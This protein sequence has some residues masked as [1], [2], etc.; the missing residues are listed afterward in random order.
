MSAKSSGGYKFFRWRRFSRIIE[1]VFIVVC[2]IGCTVAIWLY[3][4]DV[5][6]SSGATLPVWGRAAISPAPS[7]VPI[8]EDTINPNSRPSLVFPPDNYTVSSAV[9][10]DLFYSWKNPFSYQVIFQISSRSDFAG[11][12]VLEKKLWGTSIQGRFLPP[13]VY[14]WRLS[15][16]I[17]VNTS[18]KDKSGSVSFNTPPT[19]LVILPNFGAPEIYSPREGENLRIMDGIPVDFRWEKIGY[20]DTYDFKLFSVGNSVPLYEVSSLR[21]TVVQVYFNSRT[22]GRFRWTAQAN[23]ESLNEV[24]RKQ[25]LIKDHYF[26]IGSYGEEAV[27]GFVR[28][29][30]KAGAIHTPITLLVPL[31]GVSMMNNPVSPAQVRWSADERIINA[32]VFFSRDQDPAADPRAIIVDAEEDVTSI[33]LPDLREGV[34][35]WIVQGNTAQGQGLSAAEPYWFSILPLPPL[36]SPNY[37]YPSEDDVIT[38]EQLTANRNLTF[39][40]ENVSEANAYI[41]TI[42]DSENQRILYT[43]APSPETSFVLTD[44]AILTVNEYTWQVEAISV[45]RSGTIERRGILRQASFM[46][47]IPRSD[48][49]RTR[50]QGTIYGY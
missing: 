50:S 26:S 46:V 24:T 2:I 13:G 22:V 48:N 33:P 21:D 38:L 9:T 15:M 4:R 19:R 39:T 17:P 31:V 1:R 30:V 20:A 23:T 25:G 5:M 45:T 7:A 34:W 41:F 14:Y 49:L 42:F 8:P 47:H 6:G 16:Q 12:L 37:I 36:D 43:S 18:E 40:W 32:R 11:D 28:G 3:Q 29:V 35:Y 27:P 10:P 44:L